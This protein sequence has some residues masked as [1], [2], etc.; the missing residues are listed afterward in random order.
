MEELQ[1]TVEALVQKALEGTGTQPKAPL[2]DDSNPHEYMY[3]TSNLSQG[4]LHRE[5]DQCAPR[6]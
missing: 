1:A 4:Y 2:G 5:D 6:G 3:S